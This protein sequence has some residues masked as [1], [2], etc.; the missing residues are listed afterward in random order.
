LRVVGVALAV[1]SARLVMMPARAHGERFTDA[2]EA[3]N[4][5]D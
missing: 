4:E 1:D 2:I 3:L 5:A